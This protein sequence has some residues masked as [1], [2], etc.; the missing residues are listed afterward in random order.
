MCHMAG[1]CCENISADRPP[2]T[3]LAGN[4][5]VRGHLN[6][7]WEWQ[8]PT[9]CC[10][11]SRPLPSTCAVLL[12]CFPKSSVGFSFLILV[13][14]LRDF[15]EKG[16]FLG[17]GHPKG[18]RKAEAFLYKI[19][20]PV[21]K[22]NA[23]RHGPRARANSVGWPQMSHPLGMVVNLTCAQAEYTINWHI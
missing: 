14:D 1:G 13:Q 6:R 3:I 5:T 18:K 15:Y 17:W 4:R 22:R 2:A 9:L 10:P 20:P 7:L 8:P 19:N 11:I 21:C 12:K 23:S 16:S